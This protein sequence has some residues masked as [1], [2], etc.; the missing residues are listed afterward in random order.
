MNHF[1]KLNCESNDTLANIYN[2]YRNR[3]QYAMNNFIILRAVNELLLSIKDVKLIPGNILDILNNSL[4]A[5]D[6]FDRDWTTTTDIRTI[7]HDVKNEKF[8]SNVSY[9]VLVELVASLDEAMVKITELYLPNMDLANIKKKKY[10][11]SISSKDIVIDSKTLIYPYI[12]CRHC[13]NNTN[14]LPLL[15][16]D[17]Q[18]IPWINMTIKLR[19]MI[20][21]NDAKF[22][23]NEEKNFTQKNLTNFDDNGYLKFDKNKI[24]AIFNYHASHLANFICWLDSKATIYLGTEFNPKVETKDFRKANF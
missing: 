5:S 19:H 6:D 13:C 1:I 4:I 16:S 17:R 7:W 22:D 21:H 18:V 10:Q 9:P 15:F 20:I 12:V 24:D 8:M 3:T 14:D 11:T 23:Q 2:S